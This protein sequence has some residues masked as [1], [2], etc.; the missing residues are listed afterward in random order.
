M[1]WNTITIADV[2]LKLAAAEYSSVTTASLPDGKTGSDI[3][4]EEI[5]NAI[6]EVRGYVAGR[7]ANV[8]GE[9]STVPDELRDTTLALIRY[10]VFT[11]LPG[12]KKLLDE[13]RVKEYDEALRKLR[14]VAAGRFRLVNPE[15]PAAEQAG[16]SSIQV[17][18]KTRPWGR[19]RNTH[20][21]F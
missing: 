18:S 2:Q 19:R 14:D 4:N 21:L 6:Q 5:T 11:R 1:A 15:T 13:L 8:Q 10:R 20:G 9:G 12:M 3:V 7:V 17:I 16:G